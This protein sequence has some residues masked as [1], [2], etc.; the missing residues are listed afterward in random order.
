MHNL[1]HTVKAIMHGLCTILIVHTFCSSL[2]SVFFTNTK[3]FKNTDLKYR[4]DID[5]HTWFW[6]LLALFDSILSS[7]IIDGNWKYKYA[8][9]Q[10]N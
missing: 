2:I 4:H 7:G 1:L 3:H 9:F 8:V 10:I 6:L 5:K